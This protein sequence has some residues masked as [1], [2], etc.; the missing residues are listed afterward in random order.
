MMNNLRTR[1]DARLETMLADIPPRQRPLLFI[2]LGLLVLALVW[3]LLLAPLG[4]SRDALQREIAG[5]E[6]ELTWMREAAREVRRYAIIADGN[7]ERGGDSPLAA[8]D[9]SAREYGLGRAM[10]RVEPAGGEVRVWLEDAVFD[11]LLRWLADLDQTHGIAAAEVVVEPARV[12]RAR[13]NARLTLT[14]NV[15]AS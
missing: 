1:L 6:Q 11:D 4:S 12:G 15:E 8:I 5:K 13:V 9:S 2:G 3:L 7:D 14:R 10:Q